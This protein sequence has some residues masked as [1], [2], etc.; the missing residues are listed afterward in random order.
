MLPKYIPQAETHCTKSR[1]IYDVS[2]IFS[3]ECFYLQYTR[4]TCTCTTL[5][6]LRDYNF[7]RICKTLLQ[8]FTVHVCTGTYARTKFPLRP[9][10]TMS[11]CIFG[12]SQLP[13]NTGMLLWRND[14]FDSIGV[15]PPVGESQEE[16]AP[17]RLEKLTTS[18]EVGQ[19]IKLSITQVS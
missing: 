8:A 12:G 16:Q 14:C 13:R 15:G 11:C 2:R 7:S 3:A 6:N 18:C 9:G 4:R 5:H 10:I 1:Q 19:L 17:R